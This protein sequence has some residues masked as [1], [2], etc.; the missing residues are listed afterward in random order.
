SLLEEKW[1]NAQVDRQGSY[2][3]ER[4]ESLDHYCKTKSTTHVVLV[5]LVTP[6]PA[7][8]AALILESLPLQPPSDGWVANWVFWVR[9][10]VICFLLT[11]NGMLVLRRLVVGLPL[12]LA[13]IMVISTGVSAGFTGFA[14][15]LAIV[16]GFPVPFVMLVGGIPNV[17]VIGLMLV[18]VLGIAPF[19][20]SSPFRPNL[21]KFHNFLVAHE[22]MVAVYPLVKV[23]YGFVPTKYQG[24]TRLLLPLWK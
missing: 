12:T 10:T 14:I 6:L 22:T 15:M 9:V 21:V 23:L 3:I 7:L 19:R 20:S 16:V 24:F 2:S 11:T 5:C 18:F 8:A 17:I 4:L 1:E 13:K